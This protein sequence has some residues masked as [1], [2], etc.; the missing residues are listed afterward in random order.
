LDESFFQRQL[1]N[2]RCTVLLD[3]LDESP[4]Q[5][6][7]RRLMQLC[8]RCARTY[9][10]CRF[11]VTSRPAAYSADN[12]LDGFTHAR[13][14]PLGDEA[15]T[16]FVERWSS[17]L[18][19]E[20]PTAAAGHAASLLTAL[21]E[22]VEI[23][24]MARNPVMLTA[25]AVVHWNQRRLPEQRA[26]LY[27][28][29]IGWLLAARENRPGREKSERTS[30]LLGELALAM[31]EHPDGLRVQVSKRWA[32]ERLAPLFGGGRASDDESGAVS[33]HAAPSGASRL[34]AE[35]IAR[36][37]RFL[38]DEEL[39][40]GIIV[41]RGTDV[42]F[43]HRTFQEHLA[44]RAITAR[45]DDEQTSKLW[46]PPERVYSPEWREVM[47]LLGGNLH[48]LGDSGFRVDRLV[49]QMLERV[50]ASSPL[51]DQA[52]CAGL[53]GAMERDLRPVGY[54]ISDPR[55][56][57]LLQR[58]TAIFDR[59]RAATIPLPDRIAAAEAL[60]H[61][62]DAR[63]DMRSADY[64]V[65]FPAGSFLM[66]AQKSDPNAPNFDADAY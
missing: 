42:T 38:N 35:T 7:R 46:G 40:S 52:R 34:T 45:P 26:E 48:G 10:G 50:T 31:Q 57:E 12:V 20:N 51:A 3:G 66:G 49:G 21:R 22:V 18:H 47:L 53:L 1:L 2:G 36:A 65:S 61:A 8:K 64:W 55:Y 9:A 29:I 58:V 43:W 13:I 4:D 54:R 16:T 15:V 17:K 62:G 23:K 24:E 30:F 33:A 6:A 11:V 60:G 56:S 14:D 19:Q 27:K 37:E 41:G 32:A 39:D 44:A 5:V 25:F 59:D 28:A 63:L